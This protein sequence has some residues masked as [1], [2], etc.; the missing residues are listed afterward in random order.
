M[1]GTTLQKSTDKDSAT[2]EARRFQNAFW[3]L[4]AAAVA[5]ILLADPTLA[6][7]D[8]D[9]YWHVRTGLDLLASRTFPTTDTYS[10]TFAGQPWIAKEWLGQ[11]LFALAFKAAG[12]NGVV[13][14]SVGAYVLTVFLLARYVGHDLK[15]SVTFALVFVLAFLLLTLY[16][17]RPYILTFPIIVVWTA[18]LFR[19]A[20]HEETP[21]LWLLPLLVLWANL[22]AAYFIGFAIAFA[23]FLDLFA[24]VRFSKP[25]LLI[26]W[27]A[28][29]MACPIAILINPYG[30]QV[31]PVIFAVASGNEAVQLIGEWR[32]FNARELYFHETALMAMLLGLFVS[33]FR[34]AWTKA[35]FAVL[36]LHLFLSHIRFMYLVLLLVPIIISADVARQYPA[37]SAEVWA[38]TRRNDMLERFLTTRTAWVAGVVAFLLACGLILNLRIEPRP[39]NFLAD[40][41]GYAKKHGL[42]GNVLNTFGTGG[43][44]VFHGV[45]TFIDGRTDQLFLGGF[46][47]NDVETWSASGKAK[48]QKEIDDYAISWALLIRED[49]RSAFFDEFPDWRMAY[50][51]KFAV[52]YVRKNSTQ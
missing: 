1:L 47:K 31:I 10:H 2:Q 33:G 35:L 26:K 49:P 7:R 45:K 42:S 52:I 43:T 19:A 24:R 8:G 48:L 22:H 41:L 27:V 25:K 14:L 44:L 23:A 46:M 5:A 16:N 39:E 20:E 12:W 11:I 32:P 13:L 30:A 36:A 34:V 50:K 6:L 15:P 51:D 17:A 28:F 21:P 40:A 4:L 9:S 37:L 18:R 3:L 29:G 38:K